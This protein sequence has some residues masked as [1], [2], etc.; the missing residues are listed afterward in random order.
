MAEPTGT[1]SYDTLGMIAAGAADLT[2]ADL[3]TLA[4][5]HPDTPPRIVARAGRGSRHDPAPPPLV[6]ALRDEHG[7]ARGELAVHLPPGAA[8]PDGRQLDVFAALATYAVLDLL[9]LEGATKRLRLAEV[10]RHVVRQAS[11][12]PTL[13]HVLETARSAV[14]EGL[15]ALGMWIQTTDDS[16]PGGS[17]VFSAD[18]RTI[19]FPE[20]IQ[21][22]AH[23]LGLL[24]WDTQTTTVL[25]HRQPSRLLSAA[26]AGE[27]A[28]F[29]ATLDVASALLVP[30]G[31]GHQSLGLLVVTRDDTQPAWTDDEAVAALEIGRD[32]GVAV[33]SVRAAAYERR[34]ERELHVLE[35]RLAGAPGSA[36]PAGAPEPASPDLTRTRLQLREA[37]EALDQVG[38]RRDAQARILADGL[39]AGEAAAPRALAVY[40]ALRTE[41]R[42]AQLY[43]QVAF[44]AWQ[45]VSARGD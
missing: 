40:R 2:H 27:V 8:A 30:I 11:E 31:A 9:A 18:G 1:R 24:L 35:A 38:R 12:Q 7:T 26:R 39:A 32:L 4:L 14:L 23:D 43:W 15:G 20:E 29:I 34:L 37:S 22:I 33:L 3:V 16:G 25:D 6:L 28:A 10:A 17:T 5:L 36:A 44:D 13:H 21:A 45:E 41:Y 19:E 42:D